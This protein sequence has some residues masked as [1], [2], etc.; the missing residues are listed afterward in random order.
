[1]SG[2]F[3]SMIY[4]GITSTDQISIKSSKG[5]QNADL[6]TTDEL[7][8]STLD[9]SQTRTVPVSLFFSLFFS[10]FFLWL[11]V[12]GVH[13]QSETSTLPRTNPLSTTISRTVPHLPREDG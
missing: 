12:L 13:I 1:M 2:N 5:A 4:M 11:S 7:F 8:A 9:F 10:F 3:R 6:S